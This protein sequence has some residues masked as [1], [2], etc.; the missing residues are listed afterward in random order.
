MLQA[1]T[2]SVMVCV[3]SYT[4]S[5]TESYLCASLKEKA[6]E[7]RAGTHQGLDAILCDLIT[8]GD[9]ELLEK[10]TT[11]TGRRKSEKDESEVRKKTRKR[12]P[13]KN[14]AVKERYRLLGKK[15]TPESFE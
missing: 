7:S 9:V 3:P 14:T 4:K 1:P 13:K 10:G 5:L 11:L 2:S 12:L 6:F 15:K 8:P